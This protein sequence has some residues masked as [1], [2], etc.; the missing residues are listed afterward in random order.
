MKKDCIL[1]TIV[2]LICAC[3]G[4]QQPVQNVQNDSTE[5]VEQK[6]AVVSAETTECNYHHETEVGDHTVIFEM[7]GEWPAADNAVCDSVREWLRKELL[8]SYDSVMAGNA[9]TA[10]AKGC[11]EKFLRADRKDDGG[12]AESVRWINIAKEFESDSI[13]SFSFT[14]TATYSSGNHDRAHQIGA[15][16]RK[17]D[18]HRFTWADFKLRGVLQGRHVTLAE[19]LQK[20]MPEYE[21]RPYSNPEA[22]LVLP[23]NA[24]FC[25]G[26]GLMFVYG[27]YEISGI[28]EEFSQ[29][30]IPYSDMMPF[31]SKDLTHALGFLEE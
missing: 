24:P 7:R 6:K 11:E 20:N 17:R 12:S 30:V 23:E 29:G 28:A 5:T 27:W 21:I 9:M 16:F 25:V 18:G 14:E 13:V 8:P 1:V 15:T 22:D 10:F 3:G 4:K 26:E 2:A 19:L 31:L